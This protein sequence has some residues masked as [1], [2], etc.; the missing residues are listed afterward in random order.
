MDRLGKPHIGNR[1]RKFE[2][3]FEMKWK[4]NRRKHRKEFKWEEIESR[5]DYIVS[6]IENICLERDR[7]N[8]ESMFQSHTKPKRY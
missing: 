4:K 1:E 2:K 5:P 6:F 7:K 8:G 3:V